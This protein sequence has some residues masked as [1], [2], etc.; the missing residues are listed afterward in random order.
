ME[1][2]LRFFLSQEERK[3]IRRKM[4]MKREFKHEKR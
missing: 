2:G 3:E 4:D 1:G